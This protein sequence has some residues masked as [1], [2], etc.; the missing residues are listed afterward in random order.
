[1]RWER[2]THSFILKDNKNSRRKYTKFL[3]MVNFQK[4]GFCIVTFLKK[5]LQK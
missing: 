2:I 3:T 4:I 5:V 1:M